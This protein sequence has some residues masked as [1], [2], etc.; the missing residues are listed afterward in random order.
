MSGRLLKLLKREAKN[1]RGEE[2]APAEKGRTTSESVSSAE[3]VPDSR[4]FGGPISSFYGKGAVGWIHWL[5]AS[6]DLMPAVLKK[7]GSVVFRQKKIAFLCATPYLSFVNKIYNI[8]VNLTHLPSQ[9]IQ[10]YT[11]ATELHSGMH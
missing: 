11:K 10:E 1:D 5:V 7:L 4:L 6:D 2:A 9:V 8:Y 3:D